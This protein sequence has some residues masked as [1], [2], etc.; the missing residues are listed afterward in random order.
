MA[1]ILGASLLFVFGS[2]A[3]VIVATSLVFEQDMKR[4]VERNLWE[5]HEQHL[6]DLVAASAGAV[7]DHLLSVGEGV[8]ENVAEQ[9]RVLLEDGVVPSP[10][11]SGPP[12]TVLRPLPSY[13]HFTMDSFYCSGSSDSQKECPG[14]LGPLE[15]RLPAASGHFFRGQNGSV[16]HPS[17]YTFGSLSGSGSEREQYSAHLQESPALRVTLNALAAMDGDFCSILRAHANSTLQ[18]YAAVELPNETGGGHHALRLTYPGYNL[19]GIGPPGLHRLDSYD[20]SQRHWFRE[21]QEAAF[22]LQG[23]YI[24]TATKEK[25]VTLSVK[26]TFASAAS[27]GREV[28]VV[29]AAVLHLRGLRNLLRR[30]L[31][32]VPGAAYAMLAKP[33]GE[34]VTF[35]EGTMQHESF[36]PVTGANLKLWEIEEDLLSERERIFSGVAGSVRVKR[37]S[38]A[39]GFTEWLVLYHPILG[40]HLGGST[41]KPLVFISVVELVNPRERQVD[42]PRLLVESDSNLR[43]IKIDG[44]LVSAIAAIVVFLTMALCSRPLMPPLKYLQRY[45]TAIFEATAT[46]WG[47]ENDERYSLV[48]KAISEMRDSQDVAVK[49]EEFRPLVLGFN[50]MA[51]RL[52]IV[53]NVKKSTPRFPRNPLHE[54][55]E[56]LLAGR[57]Q[58][59]LDLIQKAAPP[60]QRSITTLSE[61]LSVVLV[62]RL[63]SSLETG[64]DEEAQEVEE[65][66][67]DRAGCFEGLV[68]R[69]SWKILGVLAFMLSLSCIVTISAFTLRQQ[70]RFESFWQKEATEVFE[71]AFLV[72]AQHLSSMQAS[73]SATV[74]E[75]LSLDTIMSAKFATRLLAGELTRTVGDQS[76]YEFQSFSMDCGIASEGCWGGSAFAKDCGMTSRTAS[77]TLASGYFSKYEPRYECALEGERQ[78]DNLEER[79]IVDHATTKLTALLDLKSRSLVRRRGDSSTQVQIGLE[80]SETALVRSFPYRQEPYGR[81]TEC[82]YDA[83][84]RLLPQKYTFCKLAQ[85]GCLFN[86]FAPYDPRCRAWY[87]T[88]ARSKSTGDVSLVG[89]SLYSSGKMSLSSVSAITANGTG[90]GELVGVVHVTYDAAELARILRNVGQSSQHKSPSSAAFLVLTE[91]PTSVLLHSSLEGAPAHCFGEG[92]DLSSKVVDLA[93]FNPRFSAQEWKKME[94]IMPFISRLSSQG[95]SFTFR[96]TMNG[97]NMAMSS[98]P[99]QTSSGEFL[100]TLI[101][102]HAIDLDQIDI[103]RE[104]REGIQKTVKSQRTLLIVAMAL[105][106]ACLAAVMTLAVKIASRSV[107]TMHAVCESIVSGEL[108]K[109]ASNSQQKKLLMSYEI[110]KVLE[111]FSSTLVILRCGLDFFF[112]GSM[113][114]AIRNFDE[115]EQ[116]FSSVSNDRGLGIARNNLAIAHMALSA[117]DKAGEK[118]MLSIGNAQDSLQ[119]ASEGLRQATYKMGGD[120]KLRG[121]AISELRQA[122]RVLSDRMGNYASFLLTDDGMAD[123][124]DPEYVIEKGLHIDKA[125][126]NRYGWVIKQSL[127]GRLA[128]RQGRLNEAR[129]IF[130]ATLE[131]VAAGRGGMNMPSSPWD[132]EELA[133]AQQLSMYNSYLMAHATGRPRDEMRRLLADC[134]SVPRAHDPLMGTLST[135]FHQLVEL[136]QTKEERA[137]L[138]LVA[139]C[140]RLNVYS[141]RTKKGAKSVAPAPSMRRRRGSRDYTAPGS[142]IAILE[143]F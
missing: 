112:S 111:A 25:V 5:F 27:G 67:K 108:L 40:D 137:G 52:A 48:V 44:V 1:V 140:C 120:E 45:S 113:K 14:D 32:S 34:V 30:V 141:K 76:H 49:N 9:A 116:L 57:T 87:Q 134:I 46:E 129:Q 80:D 11:G 39:E 77:S 130:D 74:I 59:C 98:T 33:D 51:K 69:T 41:N 22:A 126:G 110:R 15:S 131:E 86:T 88:A 114:D 56:L 133:A 103:V 97:Q 26:R 96:Y 17:A 78:E 83:D 119:Q 127:L 21:A 71:E 138:K 104:T 35:S 123:G 6:R 125:L 109:Y 139:R 64:L 61:R 65:P 107:R 47:R 23:P 18:I 13:P 93:C 142:A 24:E 10:S 89:S 143:S 79:H 62:P 54:T 19:Q 132:P 90:E 60:D 38:E 91:N 43:R 55:N 81:P 100:S 29:G 94:E 68:R 31:V 28:T 106:L 118:F 84:A 3:A 102:V 72:R 66:A 82:Y 85:Q 135:A 117:T 75:M 53:E 16:Q 136:S 95:G 63:L 8:A 70:S 105:I 42:V 20:P 7:E 50:K 92:G 122:M 121:A 37:G 4:E 73:I 101:S 12:E 128:L 58:E 36:D 2:C 115:A 99:L 124:E